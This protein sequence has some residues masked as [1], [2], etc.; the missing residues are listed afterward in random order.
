MPKRGC[1]GNWY[2]REE[3]AGSSNPDILSQNITARTAVATMSL[4][5]RHPIISI[6]G[7]FRIL[8]AHRLDAFTFSNY[9]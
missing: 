1:I 5:H 8:S 4:L 2:N 6:V 3:A 9:R 7:L